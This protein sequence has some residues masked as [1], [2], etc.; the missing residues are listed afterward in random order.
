MGNNITIRID[1]PKDILLA[2]NI[3]E[4]NAAKDIKQYLA[5]YLFKEKILSLGK[6]CE[7]SQ[8]SKAEFMELVGQAK[9]PLNYDVDDYEE[10]LKTIRSM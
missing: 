5:L 8:L 2:A 3:S 7:L 1:F 9:I 10:D 6:A 4:L